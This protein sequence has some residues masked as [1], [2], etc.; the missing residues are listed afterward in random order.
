MRFEDF[1]KEVESLEKLAEG[2]RGVVYKG[3]WRGEDVSIKVARTP[4]VEEAI[5]KEAEILERLKGLEMFPQM[6]K[7]GE[8]FFVYR[9][10]EGDLYGKLVLSPEEDRAVLR[11]VLEAAYLLDRMGIKRDEFARI[12]KNVLVGEGGEVYILDFERGGFKRRPSNLTQ[13]L[14]LL[15]RKG[16]LSLEEA[17]ELGRRYSRDM[18]GVFRE[19]LERLK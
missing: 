1:K 14:Q 6:L 4:E 11:K 18:E 10:I 12:D 3:R 5:R 17:K 9:F 15:V 2:W 16:Y 13:F 8:D 19:V 7:R